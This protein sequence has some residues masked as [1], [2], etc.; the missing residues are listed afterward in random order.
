MPDDDHPD[1]RWLAA[2]RWGMSGMM[3]ILIAF[4]GF[5]GKALIDTTASNTITIGRMGEQI[6]AL[7]LAQQ[8]IAAASFTGRDAAQTEA[9]QAV[10]DAAQDAELDR[11]DRR[12]MVVEDDARSRGLVVPRGKQ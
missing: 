12:L 10:I 2:Y 1:T 6:A 11:Q 9:R 4:V 7:T 3:A 8:T 5:I